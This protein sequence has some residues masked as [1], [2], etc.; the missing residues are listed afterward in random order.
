MCVSTGLQSVTVVKEKELL[1]CGMLFN[2]PVMCV[3]WSDQSSVC[4]CVRGQL[5]FYSVPSL[6]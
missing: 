1:A 5:E 2:W 4:V 3:M 6:C